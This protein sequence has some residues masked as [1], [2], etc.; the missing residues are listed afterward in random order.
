MVDDEK[1][2]GCDSRLAIKTAAGSISLNTKK[3]AEI[4][5]VFS[6]V[7]T[8]VLA[9]AFV[10]HEQTSKQV[11]TDTV[12]AMRAMAESLRMNSCLISQPQEQRQA[13]FAN[14]AGFCATMSKMQ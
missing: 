13:E 12:H 8:S 2:E 4:I 10:Q 6:L 5:A 9:Y 3:T 14:R 7:G 11:A 1:K